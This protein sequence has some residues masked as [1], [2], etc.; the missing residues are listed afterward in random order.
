MARNI[1]IKARLRHRASVE[2]TTAALAEH[3]PE[4]IV[5]DDTFFATAQGRLKLRTF[6]D[7]HGELIFYRRPDHSGPKTSF[8]LLSTTPE[9]DTL[10]ESLTLAWG[11]TGRV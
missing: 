4:L 3:G 6:V 1:E 9:P 11:Q 10:R 5:Q 8:Y 2:A 7:G